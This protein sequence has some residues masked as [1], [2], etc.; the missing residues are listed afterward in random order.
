M[1]MNPALVRAT[2]PARMLGRGMGYNALVLSISAAAGPTLAAIILSIA[3]WPWLF[4]VNLPVGIAAVAV[5]IRA[6]PRAGGHGHQVDWFSALL[7]MAMMGC[8]IFGVE[9]MS[10]AGAIATG[11]A[12][13][14]SGIAAGALLVRREWGDPAPLFPVD[15]LKIRIFA[16]RSRPRPSRS[17]RR[18]WRS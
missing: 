11:L 18:C 6:I 5:S 13:I 14:L 9:T 4:L 17:R 16:C 2:Y 12:L 15:L 8:V 10:S 1:S 7:S 3:S